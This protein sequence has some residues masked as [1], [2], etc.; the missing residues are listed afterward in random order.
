MS[1]LFPRLALAA[2]LAA[3][4][5]SASLAQEWAAARGD[6]VLVRSRPGLKGEVITR[7]ARG[8]RVLVLEEGLPAARPDEPVTEW[9]R[10]ELPEGTHVWVS[11]DYVDPAA[12]EVSTRLLNVRAG[13]GEDFAVLGRVGRG[14]RLSVAGGTNGWL[15][16]LA[17]RGLSG[18]VAAHLLEPILPAPEPTPAQTSSPPRETGTHRPTAPP[19]APPPEPT[20]ADPAPDPPPSPAAR[21]EAPVPPPG[22]PAP[23]AAGTADA[24][25]STAETAFPDTAPRRRVEREGVVRHTWSIQAPTPYELRDTDTGRR[26][27]Y[28]W[29][30]ERGPDLRDFRGRRVR[31]RGEE[32]LDPRWATPLIRVE[33]LVLSP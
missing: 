2:A 26:L 18:Y 15:E 5:A 30:G 28:L 21:P 19:P 25:A 10:I 31:V 24:D 1:R 9:T 13:P 3:G 17:P 8:Q 22:A 27:N 4:G 11:A 23:K 12:H 29:T 7:L 32:F 6:R 16:I 14:T 33:H 20:P